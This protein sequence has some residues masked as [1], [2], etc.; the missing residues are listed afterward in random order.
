M[1]EIGLI[2]GANLV[3]FGWGM[4]QFRKR[5]REKAREDFMELVRGWD[6]EQRDAGFVLEDVSFKPERYGFWLRGTATW[7]S[8][9]G[10]R[11]TG[12]AVL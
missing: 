1:K 9:D 8:A 3:A 7:R 5:D 10:Q 6:E 11:H 12:S 4:Y 2:V